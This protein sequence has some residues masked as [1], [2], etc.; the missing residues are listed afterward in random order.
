MEDKVTL[1]RVE[2]LR[3]PY[4]RGVAKGDNPIGL[5]CH[6]TKTVGSSPNGQPLSTTTTFLLTYLYSSSLP[7]I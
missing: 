2:L 3:G 4:Q 5:L 1:Q 6:L 7:S